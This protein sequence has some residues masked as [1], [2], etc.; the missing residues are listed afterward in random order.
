MALHHICSWKVLMKNMNF[1]NCQCSD[2]F[3][4]FFTINISWLSLL[5]FL[6][7]A[8]PVKADAPTYKKYMFQQISICFSWTKIRVLNVGG[9]PPYLFLRCTNEKHELLQLFTI[10]ITFL[11]FLHFFNLFTINITVLT[12]K[13]YS[14]CN[15][16]RTHNHLAR[17]W[18]LNHLAKLTKWLTWIVST[19]MYGA[20]DC[21]FSSCYVR[22]SK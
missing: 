18:T 7:V 21:K 3:V 8:A 15:G 14:D 12:V 19:Y 4:D 22:V 20:F 10:N 9:T 5:T 6:A 1:Y 11:P 16:T 13:T 17:K 2:V